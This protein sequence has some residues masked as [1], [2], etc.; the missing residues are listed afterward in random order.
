VGPE[1]SMLS[2]QPMSSELECTACV[3]RGVISPEASQGH[4]M[5]SVS[6]DLPPLSTC[7][8]SVCLQGGG[9]EN[10]VGEKCL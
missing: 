3:C 7:I 5:V 8:P 1:S 6:R 2:A 10:R 4:I 9:R